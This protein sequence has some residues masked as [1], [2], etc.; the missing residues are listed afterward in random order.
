METMKKNV[1]PNP[2]P[3]AIVTTK[4]TAPLAIIKAAETA[5]EAAFKA[6]AGIL[7]GTPKPGTLAAAYVVIDKKW[8]KIVEAQRETARALLMDVVDVNG[9]PST[10]NPNTL[11]TSVDYDG[12]TFR[13]QRRQGKFKKPDAGL[14]CA[15]LGEKGLGLKEGC[16]EEISY[17]PNDEKLSALVASGKLTEEELASCF[18]DSPAQLV[19]D[20]L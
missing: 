16:D 6:M 15:L 13:V 18:K 14:V 2:K 4:P 8:K 20:K 17:V 10:E 19:V 7:S 9:E 12:S 11:E 3:M 1:K 5:V